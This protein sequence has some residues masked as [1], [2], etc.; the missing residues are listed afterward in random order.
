MK[1]L[2]RLVEDERGLEGLPLQLMIIALVLSLGLPVVYSSIRYQDTQRVLQDLEEQA[3]F[4]GEK[5]RQIY[6]HGEG[7]SDILTLQ[8]EDGMFREIEFLEVTNGT[9][10]DQ[11][12]WKLRG[13]QGGRHFVGDNFPLISEE[14]PLRLEKGEHR[15]RLECKFGSPSEMEEELLYIEVSKI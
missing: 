2:K 13:G 8:L 4:I 3:V 5:A 7:N 6:L 1:G 14:T 10:R 9:Y 11:I 15:L 12:Q